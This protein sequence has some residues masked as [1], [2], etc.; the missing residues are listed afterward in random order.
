MCYNGFIN[1]ARFLRLPAAALAIVDPDLVGIADSG[2]AGKEGAPR[3]MLA[4]LPRA[5]MGQVVLLTSPESFH[6]TQLLSRQQPTPVTRLAATLTNSLASVANKRL[7]PG[8][9]PL[10]ATLTKNRGGGGVMVN[11]TSDEECLSRATIRSDGPLFSFG[12]KGPGTLGTNHEL[13]APAPVPNRTAPCSFPWP[14]ITVLSSSVFRLGERPF[15]PSW[16][17]S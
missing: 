13:P 1:S 16:R 14:I 8:L 17:S 10:D 2:P 5:S 4:R 15:A 6:P 9:N 11:Q 7:T 3:S 12:S